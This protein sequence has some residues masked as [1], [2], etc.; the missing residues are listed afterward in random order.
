MKLLLG[1]QEAENIPTEPVWLIPAKGKLMI[2]MSSDPLGYD[3]FFI[4]RIKLITSKNLTFSYDKKNTI[5]ERINLAIPT[6]EFSLLI[7]PSGCGK[8]T[9][10]KILARLY[11]KYAGTMSGTLDL[12]NLQ[13]AL[14][15]QKANE[16]FTMATPREEIIFALENLQIS[17]EQYTKRLQQAVSFAEISHLLDQKINT[18]SGGE[19]Q[20]VALAVLVAMDVDVFLLDEPFASCDP[21]TRKFLITK[22]AHLR[23]LGKTIILS[24]HILSDYAGI[25]DNL[26][27][28]RDKTIVKLKDKEL[29]L[30]AN[31]QPETYSF[32][33]PQHEKSCFTFTNTKIAQNRLLLS[34]QELKIIAGKTTLITGANG[35]GKTSLFAALTKMLPYQG[36][37]T[38]NK[39]EI[40]QLSPRKYLRQVGQIFQVATDQFINV[41]VLDELNLSK[42]QRTNNFFTDEKIQHALVNLH[43]DQLLDQV[44]YSLSGGQQKKLQILLMLI[45]NQQVLLLDEPLSGLDQ[46]SALQVMKL[47]KQSQAARKQTLLIISHELLNLAS[48]CDY[49]LVLAQ[50]QLTYVTK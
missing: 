30:H 7:G 1:C 27:Q 38:F 6:G 24:D 32:A 29:L 21:T 19:Q 35:T 31:E 46:D 17:R 16:Q 33:L 37:L 3:D 44:V 15:F 5:L 25:C 20:R 14:M 2:F 13:V 4:L 43:L 47:I 42:K 22:L 39:R 9:F 50:Q 12:N 41:T 11:P 45:S 26:L 34:Q 10:L 40:S 23:D 18:M 28:F 48:W 8:S 36:S 49:H